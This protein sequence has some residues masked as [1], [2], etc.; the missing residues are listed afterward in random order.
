MFRGCASAPSTWATKLLVR[1]VEKKAVDEPTIKYRF[2]PT[3][4]LKDEKIYVH[5]M[6]KK[7]GWTIQARPKS[8]KTN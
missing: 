6:A 1:V 2:D 5:K 8:K 7:R 4:E 3:K